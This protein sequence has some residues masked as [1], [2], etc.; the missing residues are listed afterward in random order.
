[1]GPNLPLRHYVALRDGRP[2][3]KSSLF[4]GAGVAGIYNV[5]TVPDARRQGIGTAVTLAPLRDAR[6]LGYRVAV[7]SSTAMAV[8][9][10]GRLG[11]REYTGIGWYEYRPERAPPRA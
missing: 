8:G 7:L 6:E 1:L 4:L 11:F 10:Y 3:A 9:M 5:S 2:V